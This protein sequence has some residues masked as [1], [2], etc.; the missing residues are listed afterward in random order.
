[1]RQN[2]NFWIG[3]MI[4]AT[5]PVIGF[6]LIENIFDLLTAQ[7]IMDDVTIS[8]AGRRQRTLAL[9][10]IM[11]NML[12]VQILRKRRYS[13]LVR[14]VLIVTFIYCG[15]WIYYFKSSLFI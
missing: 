10:A 7:G 14:G 9:L 12:I 15:L 2:D 1:M 3:L 11:C 4:G 8:T 13:E 5:I 6:W